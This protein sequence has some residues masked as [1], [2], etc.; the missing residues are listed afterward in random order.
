MQANK[1]SRSWDWNNTQATTIR[2]SMWSLL[3][4][5]FSKIMP[6]ADLIFFS[7]FVEFVSPQLFFYFFISL[8]LLSVVF[9]RFFNY[10]DGITYC[11]TIGE[12]KRVERGVELLIPNVKSNQITNWAKTYWPLRNLLILTLA[13]MLFHRFSDL[14]TLW[15]RLNNL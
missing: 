9:I 4:F 5:T 14:L 7:Y 3:S 2:R 1:V 13:R 15:I 6:G 12:E 10:W 11:S 8:I